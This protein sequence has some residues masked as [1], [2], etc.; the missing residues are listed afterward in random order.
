MIFISVRRDTDFRSEIDMGFPP[1]GMARKGI[2]AA[3]PQRTR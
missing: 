1:L 2:V 3:R